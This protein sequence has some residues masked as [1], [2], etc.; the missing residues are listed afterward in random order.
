MSRGLSEVEATAMGERLH[1]A[2]HARVADGVRGRAEPPR[3]AG[4]GSGCST[5]M[6]TFDERALASLPEVAGFT[7]DLRRPGVRRLRSPAD[8]LAGDRG[9]AL[10]R[11]LG[12]GPDVRAV[13]GGRSSGEP[14]RRAGGDPE[15]GGRHRGPLRSADPARF[16]RHGHAP[17]PDAGGEGRDLHRSRRSCGRVPGPRRALA[18]RSRPDQ[19]HALHR[20]ARRLPNRW[21]VPVRAPRHEG[22]PATADVDVRRRRRSRGLPALVDRGRGGGRGDV[23]RAV[24]L[25]RSHPRIQRRDHRDPRR[26]RRTRALRGDPGLGRGHDP[27]GDPARPD[28]AR[29]RPARRSP[30]GSGRISRVPRPRSS[31][32][33]RSGFS[34]QLGVFFA[35]GEQHFDHRSSQ[36]HVGARC[37]SDLLYRERCAIAAEPC[38]PAGS[39][40]DRGPRRPTRCRR[41]AT[42][43]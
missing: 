24:R 15:G 38:T 39:T 2:D 28:R 17:R 34:E 11:P 42:S 21:H 9:V 23:H 41:A 32:P 37:T 18:S 27:S 22:R 19:A 35:D 13:H 20:D 8:P 26:R 33:S 25:A 14:R 4:P 7:G 36:D 43:C 1:R 12:P 5:A 6:T 3:R 10:H 30:S 40:C 31:S 29:R 16:R